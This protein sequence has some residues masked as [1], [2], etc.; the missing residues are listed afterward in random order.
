MR[1]HGWP[2]CRRSAPGQSLVE[3]ALT[4]GILL[5]LIFGLAD[6]MQ[7][8][9]TSYTVA[10]AARSAAHQAAIQG[11]EDAQGTVAGLAK[12]IL[13]AGMTTD[14]AKATITVTCATSPCKRYSAVTVTV[15]YADGFWLK[16]PFF[17]Q[18]RATASSTRTA[19]QDREVGAGSG[20]HSTGG[21]TGERT[22]GTAG[23]PG[24]TTI[25][26]GRQAVPGGGQ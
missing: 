8:L 21:G 5:M 14:S 17:E 3:L 7:W 13:D 16:F 12:T 26:P 1:K 19:E 15:T 24:S 10:Q 2:A 9:M 4:L 23:L 20:A 6:T 11:G 25:L 18:V 22:P